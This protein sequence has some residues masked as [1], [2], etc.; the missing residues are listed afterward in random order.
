METS[1]SICKHA[2]I[3]VGSNTI[4]AVIYATDAAAGTARP[5][6]SEREFAGII[7]YVKHGILS[8]AGCARLVEVLKKM[9][10][11]CDIASCPNISCFSTASLRGAQNLEEAIARVKAETGITI[12]PLSARE[13]TFYDLEGLRSSNVSESGW[14]LD[15]GGGSCQVFRYD[16]E[17]MIAAISRDIGC[18]ALSNAC[19]S[20]VFPTK[21]EARRIRALVKHALED[22]YEELTVPKGTFIYAIGGSLRNAARVYAEITGTE[23]RSPSGN[24]L[25][26]RDALAEIAEFSHK[27]PKACI[28]VLA[29]LAPARM[30]TLITAVITVRAICKRLGAAG[31]EVITTGIREG[32]LRSEVFGK[33]TYV[34]IIRVPADSIPE[35]CYPCDDSETAEPAP[36][37]IPAPAEASVDAPAGDDRAVAVS[38]AEQAAVAAEASATEVPA[39]EVPAA[40]TTA[41]A[42]SA[43]SENDGE[44]AA[45]AP[46]K[47]E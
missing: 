3:D 30:H 14:G 27:D 19:V 25:L 43:A 15:L 23:V 42:A 26:S 1:N 29:R 20:G 34:P 10:E 8:E 38:E 9:K 46:E 35:C 7:S 6:I 11:F 40:E 36:E 4:R 16:A 31:V 22:A 17:G 32:Y 12:R 33:S 39:A 28:R 5:L 37:D 2:V 41:S 13:E 24:A 44:A 21:K 47:T 18:L 45:S